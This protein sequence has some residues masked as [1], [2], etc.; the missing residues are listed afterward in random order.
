MRN[1]SL[2]LYLEALG[3][4]GDGENTAERSDTVAELSF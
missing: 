2:A 3:Q 4:D 1:V